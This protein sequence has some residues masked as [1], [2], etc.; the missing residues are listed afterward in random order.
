MIIK[1]EH[2]GKLV[3]VQEHLRGTHRDHCLCF[4][5][6]KFFKPETR[7]GNCEIANANFKTCVD[8]GVTLPVFECPKYESLNKTAE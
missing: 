5:E 8:F 6:C 2:Y 4:Q 3:S 7:E 1:Y